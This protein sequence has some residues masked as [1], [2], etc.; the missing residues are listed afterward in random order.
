MINQQE[1]GV[2]DVSKQTEC[3]CGFWIFVFEEELGGKNAY[4]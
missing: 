2:L 3:L 1:V 4:L